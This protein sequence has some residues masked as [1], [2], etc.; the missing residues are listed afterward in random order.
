MAESTSK[1]SFRYR[2]AGYALGFA[3]GGFFDGILL[4][5]IL[6]W[7]HLLSGL[8]GG[9]F[10]DLRF[11]I[12]A[13]GLF[14]VLMYIVGGIGLWLL[15]RTRSEFGLP[16]ADRL[17]VANALLGFGAWHILDGIASH[18]VLQIHR[19]KMDSEMPLVWDILWFAVFGVAFVAWGRMLQPKRPAR[20]AGTPAAPTA[21]AALAVLTGAGA[22]L[23]PGEGPRTATVV[24]FRPGTTPAQAMTAMTSVGGRLIWSDSRDGVW[25]IDLPGGADKLPLYGGGALLVSDSM[26]PVGCLNWFETASVPKREI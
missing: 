4:H 1:F 16:R 3:I 2:W 19:I 26:L 13:D 7:H 24:V 5:Q 12:L 14:H 17:L 15:W 11:Q 10:D 22:L 6:Q 9:R 8:E 20:G 18:W 23:P 21:L 25:A